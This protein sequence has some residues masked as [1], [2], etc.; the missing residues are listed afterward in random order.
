M[1][2]SWHGTFDALAA[3][4]YDLPPGAPWLGAGLESAMAQLPVCRGWEIFLGVRLPPGG[5]R[6]PVAIIQ[7]GRYLLV[8]ACASAS[9]PSQAHL[10]RVLAMVRDVRRFHPG[11]RGLNAVPV[12]I[13]TESDMRP[14]LHDGIFV[15]SPGKLY[16]LFKMLGLENT[17][18][19]AE[20]AAWLSESPAAASEVDLANDMAAWAAELLAGH[21]PSARFLATLARDQGLAMYLTRDPQVAAAYLDTRYEGNPPPSGVA[22]VGWEADLLWTGAAWE[23]GPSETLEAYRERLGQGGD[24]LL[25]V[26]P[27]DERFDATFAALAAAGPALLEG[28]N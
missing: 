16:G 19:A 18:P 7:A 11:A 26:V 23:P 15:G 13:L 12:L 25:I 3:S 17:A 14:V 1:T 9:Q 4:P 27:P 10:D 22:V 20:P 21:L 8:L 6:G 24:G 5:G 2:G 28:A